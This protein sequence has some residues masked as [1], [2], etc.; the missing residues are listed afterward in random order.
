MANEPPLQASLWHATA[1]PAPAT[2]PFVG[3]RTAD[4]AIVGAGFTGCSA[5]LHLAEKGVN[6]TVL[7]AE[8]I[9]WGGSGRNAGLVNAGMWLDPSEVI[10]LLG[11]VY[12]PRILDALDA[13]PELVARLAKR[14]DM[15]CDIVPK[16]VIRGAHNEKA[17]GGLL[18]HA[19]QWRERGANVELYDRTAFAK[20]TGSNHYVGGIVDHRSFSIQ[21][22]SY[23]RGLARAAIAAGAHLHEGARVTAVESAN[24]KWRLKTAAGVLTADKMIMAT[25]AYSDGLWPGMRET[26]IPIGCY[27]Y[28]TEPL[29]E[30]VRQSILPGKRALYDAQPSMVF[31]R[32]D[33]DYRLI[34]GSLGYLPSGEMVSPRSWA[35]RTLRYL[36]PQLGEQNFSHAWAG[37]IGF[38]SDHLPRIYEPAPGVHMVL[39]YNGRGIGPGT[40]W[41]K[42]LAERVLGMP[43]AEF[44]LPVSPVKAAPFRGLRSRFYE[45]AFS[46]YRL[47][48]LFQ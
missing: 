27:M 36:F 3:D 10:R 20:L 9:G 38:T 44:A 26:I 21:P 28:A 45:T 15:A 8:Q 2:Q 48:S 17:L 32:Y 41:G 14:H 16:G 7:E 19:R 31:A 24:G 23:A 11:P 12:G 4:V 39:G 34:V 46:A 13:A 29:S 1:A 43:A 25:N 6:V 37:T 22:L 42:V 40:Y 30:N 18:E 33:R 5:A 35:Q 47:R